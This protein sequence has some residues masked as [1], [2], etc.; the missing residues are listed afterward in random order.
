[1]VRSLSGTTCYDAPDSAPVLGSGDARERSRNRHPCGCRSVAD[2]QVTTDC[3][4][5]Y[6]AEPSSPTRGEHLLPLK[7]R[8]GR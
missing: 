8:R 2:S 1:M 7:Q 6:G 3:L 5:V 4:C